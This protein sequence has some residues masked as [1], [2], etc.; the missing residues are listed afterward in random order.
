[1]T[2]LSKPAKST[3]KRSGPTLH[4]QVKPEK[5]GAQR[6][7][8]LSRKVVIPTASTSDRGTVSCQLFV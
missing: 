1:M 4:H 6:T 2:S 8:A 5:L 7:K 3:L